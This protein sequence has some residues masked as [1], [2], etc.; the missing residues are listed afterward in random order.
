MSDA[1]LPEQVTITNELARERTRAAAERTLNA[2]IG[3]CLSLIGFGVTFEQISR[4]LRQQATLELAPTNPAVVS[5]GF[6]GLGVVLLGL[7][8][9]QHRLALRAIEQQN[10]VLL[11]IQT[12]NRWA[13]VTIVLAGL[14]GL[15]VTLLW[16]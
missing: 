7:A 3:T 5:I 8:L 9:V 13:V 12:L 14:A 1:P 16:P 15:G 2:W 4:R 11:P 10:Y 6:V